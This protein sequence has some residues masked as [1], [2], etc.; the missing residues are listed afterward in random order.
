[1]FAVSSV[2]LAATHESDRA[3]YTYMV[4]IQGS[5]VGI[6]KEV[7]T[8]QEDSFYYYFHTEIELSRLGAALSLVMTQEG[9]ES[10][11]GK[12]KWF[13]SDVKASEMGSSV[14]G[15]LKGDTIYLKSEGLGFSEELRIPW[16]EKGVGVGTVDRKIREHLRA[17]ENEFSLTVFDPERKGFHPLQVRHRGTVTDTIGGVAGQYIRIE[18]YEGEGDVPI[19]V[20][21][22]DAELLPVKI[23]TR[24]MSMVIEIERVESDVAGSIEFEPHFDVIKA[25]L[26]P[27][28]DYPGAPERVRDV[29]L[30]LIFL[31]PPSSFLSFDAPNQKVIRWENNTMDLLLTRETIMKSTLADGEKTV[32]LE[33]DRYIQS[34]HP[35]VVS[36]AEEIA[37]ETGKTGW[38]LALE[39]ADWVNQH[40]ETKDF[41]RGFASALEVLERREGDC[42][43]HAVL[44]VSLLRAA[45]IPARVVSG[46]AYGKGFLFGHMWTEAYVDHWRTLDALDRNADPIRIRVSASKD[47]SA[48]GLTDMASDYALIGGLKVEVLEY[49]LLE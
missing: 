39:L 27:L 10:P 26:I 40:I 31:R 41:S 48:L 28:P 24:Q 46:L 44:L 25:S 14:H 15:E 7:W 17:G 35:A 22:L 1:M 9:L 12:P 42:T 45:G 13:R 32:F 18:Q 6:A 43:E 33:P 29:T 20:S 34:R 8:R 37:G 21:L 38:D 47:A 16:E 49:H 36:V 19:S 5:P 11:E 4:K 2:S 3:E 30:R 23:T